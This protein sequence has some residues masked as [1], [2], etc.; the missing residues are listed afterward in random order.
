MCESYPPRLLY[1]DV[2]MTWTNGISST[3]NKYGN[4]LSMDYP[5]QQ[6]YC[7]NTANK[8]GNNSYIDHQPGSQA[9]IEI[10]YKI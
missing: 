2:E 6:K 10:S 5:F 4:D 9:S 8:A 3:E 7:K 1:A